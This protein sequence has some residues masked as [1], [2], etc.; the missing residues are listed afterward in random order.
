MNN[1]LYVVYKDTNGITET[2]VLYEDIQEFL[3]DTWNPCEKERVLYKMNFVIRGKTYQ[4]RKAAF[5]DIVKDFQAHDVGGL[6]WYDEITL[7]DYFTENARRY[8]LINELTE[9][10]II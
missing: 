9:N 1:L 6:S 5:I 3:Q 8:G 7:N 10:G 2:G 4:E